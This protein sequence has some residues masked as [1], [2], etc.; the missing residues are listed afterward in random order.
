MLDEPSTNS[1]SELL[2]SAGMVPRLCGINWLNVGPV[3][4]PRLV[5]VVLGKKI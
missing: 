4:I 2:L 5:S 3:T 1:V